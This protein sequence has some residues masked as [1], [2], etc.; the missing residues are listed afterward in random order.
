MRKATTTEKVERRGLRWLAAASLALTFAAFGCTMNRYPGNGE[1][2]SVSPS[3]GPLNHS[4][5]PGSSSGNE[6]VPPMASSYT[7]I[8]RVDTDVLATLAAEQS[9]RG[10]VLGPVNPD[11]VQVGVPIQPTGGQFV[12]PA[13]I[14]NPQVTV[15]SSISS[16][17]TP[18]ITSGTTGGGVAIAT[19]ATG[20][21]VATTGMTTGM[22]TTA[23]GAVATTGALTTSTGAGVGVTGANGT[24]IAGSAVFSPVLMNSTPAP[25]AT[26]TTNP[27]LPTIGATGRPV[28][29]TSNAT[30]RSTST[31]S[32][33]ARAS[34]MRTTNAVLTA[35]LVPIRIETGSQGQVIVTNVTMTVPSTK[36]SSKP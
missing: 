35:G 19:T 13:L 15:N 3:Y 24:T 32:T 5:T 33:T 22:A 6:G 11:G 29:A 36:P 14:T 30:A 12:S 23:T 20:T 9:F 8:S 21:T 18:V 31:T 17:P 1:P 34:T 2:T 27:T 25:Q 28:A 16:A 10:R 26:G 7:G 4:I